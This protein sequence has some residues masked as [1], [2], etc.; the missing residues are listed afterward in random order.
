MIIGLQT[1]CTD[2]IAKLT[3]GNVIIFISIKA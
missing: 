1:R 2:C 3:V